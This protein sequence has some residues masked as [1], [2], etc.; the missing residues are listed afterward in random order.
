[1]EINE[2][3]ENIVLMRMQKSESEQTKLLSYFHS[4][5]HK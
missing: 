3:E 5:A 4:A 1:M 2:I